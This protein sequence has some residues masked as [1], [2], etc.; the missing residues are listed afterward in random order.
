MVFR[1]HLVTVNGV[2]RAPAARLVTVRVALGRSAGGVVEVALAEAGELEEVEEEGGVA[3]AEGGGVGG[4]VGFGGE[5]LG[6]GPDAEGAGRAWRELGGDVGRHGAEGLDAGVGGG[7]IDVAGLVS[8]EGAAAEEAARVGALLVD[9]AARGAVVRAGLAEGGV[10]TAGDDGEAVARGGGELVL[11][12][13]DVI[14]HVAGAAE[15]AREAERGAVLGG[16]PLGWW[17]RIDRRA[18]GHGFTIP[19]RSPARVPSAPP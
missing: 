12:K 13:G 5:M 8:G 15:A 9:A 2:G 3:G 6:G 19:D 11:A 16:R 7:A 1:G 14:E 18:G 10:I 4:G 17:Q